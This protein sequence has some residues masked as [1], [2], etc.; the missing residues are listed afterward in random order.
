M[1]LHICSLRIV[2]STLGRNRVNNF[3]VWIFLKGLYID[4][5]Y[6]NIKRDFWSNSRNYLCPSNKKIQRADNSQRNRLSFWAFSLPNLAFCRKYQVCG[7][8][9]LYYGIF[10]LSNSISWFGI[11]LWSCLSSG[12]SILEWYDL[13]LRK[14]YW[15]ACNFLPAKNFKPN[16]NQE[17]LVTFSLN[18][19]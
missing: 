4:C 6:F 16:K 5:D 2:C 14:S 10:P 7:V 19:V 3:T 8:C 17:F 1:G 13:N 18:Y 15:N 12:R 9:L 11:C